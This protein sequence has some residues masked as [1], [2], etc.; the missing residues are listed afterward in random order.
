MTG[1][2]ETLQIALVTEEPF[3]IGVEIYEAGGWVHHTFYVV[4]LHLS[5]WE[6][7]LARSTLIVLCQ[8]PSL[9]I[10][11]LLCLCLFQRFITRRVL[12][13]QAA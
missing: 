9:H 7:I 3:N 11:F 8:S 4:N 13:G 5:G 1:L 2:T 12:A 10:D 6:M